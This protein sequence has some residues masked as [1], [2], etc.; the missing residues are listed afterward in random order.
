MYKGAFQDFFNEYNSIFWDWGSQSVGINHEI[1]A[2]Q[3]VLRWDPCNFNCWSECF[4]LVG[5]NQ[6]EQEKVNIENS[7][8]NNNLA[9]L[10]PDEV[11]IVKSHPHPLMQK[12]STDELCH[13][14][15]FEECIS[16]VSKSA[17]SAPKYFVCFKQNCN[18]ALWA[19]CTSQVV[20]K[21]K[22]LKGKT[23][24]IF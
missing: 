20:K 5:E 6:K 3:D 7:M 11:V 14:A 19:L 16:L 1:D 12:I 15:K 24:T 17:Q 10:K 8:L 2:E 21:V 22:K 23:W 4:Q 18:F 9:D 13:N